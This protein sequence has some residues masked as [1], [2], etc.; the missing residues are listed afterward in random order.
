MAPLP[1][2]QR[3]YLT[4]ASVAAVAGLLSGA[5]GS[6]VAIG[7]AQAGS[8]EQGRRLDAHLVESGPMTAEFRALQR[9]VAAFRSEVAAKLDGQEKLLTEVRADVKRI[10]ESGGKR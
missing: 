10:A 7:R 6:L 3:L 4:V 1:P 8:D 5:G 9:E 2:V